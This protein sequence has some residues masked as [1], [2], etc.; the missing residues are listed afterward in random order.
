MSNPVQEVNR[1]GREDKRHER[2]H[3][4]VA[5]NELPWVNGSKS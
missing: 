5:R 1:S 3:I 2:E 4:R